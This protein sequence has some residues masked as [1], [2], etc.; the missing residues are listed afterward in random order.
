MMEE[1]EVLKKSVVHVAELM[2]LSA[3]T[4]PKA[5]GVDNVESIILTEQEEL[6]ALAEKMEEL[7]PLYGDFFKRD[8]E[9][10]RK[11]DAVVLVGCR[12]V[13]LGLKKPEG[14]PIDPDLVNS[15]VNLGIAIGSAVKTASLLNVDNRVMY[16]IGVAA[17]ELK[18]LNADVVYG[19]PLSARSKNIYFDRVWP[20]R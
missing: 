6:E 8:A 19:I 1:K 14:A 9:N 12:I 20:P 16:S 7:A 5:R 10:V 13:S 3:K 18:L 4:A 17:K 15:I 2:V 11:S